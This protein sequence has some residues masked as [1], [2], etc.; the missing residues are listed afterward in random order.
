MTDSHA[1]IPEGSVTSPRDFT[2]AAAHAGRPQ[3]Q[4][5][6]ALGRMLELIT[7]QGAARGTPAS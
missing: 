6:A 4:P 7:R 1:T 2:A 5:E 3:I